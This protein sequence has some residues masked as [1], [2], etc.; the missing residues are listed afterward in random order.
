[1]SATA[2]VS[3]TL[4]KSPAGTPAITLAGPG[5]AIAGES[6]YDAG[7]RTVLFRP[8]GPLPLGAEIAV[9]TSV[10]GVTLGG[11]SWTFAT[12]TVAPGPGTTLFGNSVPARE[13]VSDPAAIE[14]GVSF[15]PTTSGAVTGVRFYKG[16]SNTGTHTG[17]L[18]STG[19]ELLATA[20]FANES[21]AGWQTVLFDQP[22]RVDAGSTYVASYLAPEGGYS[23]TPSYFSGAQQVSGEL[24]APASGNGRYRYG[25]GFPTST[26]QGTNY[27]ADVVFTADE[28]TRATVV[29]T[30]PPAGTTGVSV[31]ARISATLDKAPTGEPVLSI[32]GPSGPVPGLSSYEATTRRVVFTP[33]GDLPYDTELSAS[34]SVDGVPLAGGAWAFRT[35]A[36]PSSDGSCPCTIFE[37]A[38]RPETE[39]WN[40]PAA[41]Q[42]GVRFAPA[43]DGA[44]SG[45]RFYK[46]LA[47]TGVHTV[48]LWSAGGQL[49]ASAEARAESAAGWQTVAF[50]QPVAVT[51][52]TVY[53]AAYHSTAG[54]YAITAGGLSAPLTRGPLGTPANAG[55]YVYGTGYPAASTGTNFWVDPVY[56]DGS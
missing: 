36:A 44:V 47:N 52:G 19:G 48:T 34:A 4:S 33:S 41:V 38:D 22:V 11:G 29:R 2:G 54:R 21:A 24:T 39:A 32:S 42:V 49:L 7:R 9:T 15:A 6:T 25:G 13:S 37:D 16:P 27:F 17:S 56:R 51:A 1:M 31:T 46:G 45:I 8:S 23:A 43:A 20:T 30:S 53:T 3:A 55:A 50:D 10:D 12:E 18:W 28:P 5:G 35:A 14:L 40:D 26:W